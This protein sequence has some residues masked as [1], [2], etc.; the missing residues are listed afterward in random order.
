[1]RETG[2]HSIF[3]ENPVFYTLTPDKIT[4]YMINYLGS[5]KDQ[6]L[7]CILQIFCNMQNILCTFEKNRTI[8]IAE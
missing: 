6:V 1:M 4:V 3:N 5:M 7:I 8:I 2:M